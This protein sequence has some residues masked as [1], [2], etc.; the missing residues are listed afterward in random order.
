M[1]NYN[2]NNINKIKYNKKYSRNLYIYYIYYLIIIWYAK[3]EDYLNFVQCNKL[4]KNI[5][6]FIWWLYIISETLLKKIK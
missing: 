4:E 6:L 1:I 2:S 5:V 3:E